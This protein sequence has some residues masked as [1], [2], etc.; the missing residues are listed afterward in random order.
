MELSGQLHARTALPPGKEPPG[1]HWI[2]GWV[3]PLV[4]RDAVEKRKSCTPGNRIRA[5]PVPT[6]LSRLHWTVGFNIFLENIKRRK[7]GQFYVSVS[8]IIT[9]PL[10]S[11]CVTLPCAIEIRVFKMSW[12]TNPMW[13]CVT[14]FITIAREGISCFLVSRLEMWRG[15]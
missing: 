9:L 3:G 11:L 10:L 5:V 1:T 2:G 7:A 13:P 4:A 6:E 12:I 15:K 14:K 8:F